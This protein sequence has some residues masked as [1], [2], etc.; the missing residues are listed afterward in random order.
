MAKQKGETSQGLVVTLVFFI[1]LTIILGV[2]TWLGYSGQED[3]RKDITTATNTA[4]TREAERDWAEF[5]ALA[6][7]SMMGHQPPNADR[8]DLL[9]RQFANKELGKNAADRDEVTNLVGGVL[10]GAPPGGKGFAYD[11]AT[12]KYR[13]SYEGLLAEQKKEFDKVNA[14]NTGLQKKVKDQDGTIKQRDEQI[15]K[16]KADQDKTIADLNK[17]NTD[18]K[19]AQDTTRT[20]LIAEVKRLTDEKAAFIVASA[21]DKKKLTAD[22][23]KALDTVAD[24]KRQMTAINDELLSMKAKASDTAP[25]SLRTDWKIATIQGTIPYINLGSADN[26]KTQLTFNI[27]GVGPD[28]RPNP[29]P[30]GTLE[31]VNVIG[32]HLSQARITG[33]KDASRDPVLVGDVLNNST[34]DPFQKRHV[35]LAGYFDLY[36][37]GRENLA[38]LRRA[39]ER[40]NV[41]VDAYLDLKDFSIQGALT[42]QTDYLILGD[43][44]ETLPFSI[45]ERDDFGKKLRKGIEEVQAEAKKN[46]V[47][48]IGMRKYLDSIGYKVPRPAGAPAGTP[49]SP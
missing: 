16:L 9:H 2:T 8:L 47:P 6:Y 48:V 13:N 7:R 22:L 38:E 31:V 18:T 41:V 37:D 28:G 29:Q 46:G 12:K 45:R 4:K 14:E 43:G 19:E 20:Q 30:K 42:L 36:G 26:V 34:W 40:Q 25:K 10:E 44:P 1:L 15:T 33:V 32:P 23:K 27:H 49:G 35:A 11:E 3:A 24:Q 39:L 21:D 5:Q 17:A